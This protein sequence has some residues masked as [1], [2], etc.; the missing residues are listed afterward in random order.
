M[1]QLVCRYAALASIIFVHEC[2]HFFAARSQGIHVSKFSVGRIGL[3]LDH[4]GRHQL[5][6]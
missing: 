2:G 3:G 5:V 1:G 4:T 6:F